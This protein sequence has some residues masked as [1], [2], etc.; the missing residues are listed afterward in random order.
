MSQDLKKDLIIKAAQKRFSHFGVSKT[1]MN[2]IADDLSISKA[3]LYYY[4]PDKLN[5]YAAVLQKIIETEESNG[6]DPLKEKDPQVA[7]VSYLENRTKF[8]IQH[9]NILEY[10]KTLGTAVP[11]ELEPIFSSA[12]TREIKSIASIIKKGMEQKQLK[13]TDPQKTAELFL[14]CL[15]GLRTSAVSNKS[16]FFPNKKQF[17]DLASREKEV[18]AIF[19]KGLSN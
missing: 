17:V 4:F 19:I 2:E 18:A 10:L 1:T 14:D 7:L 3:S 5:L 15:N 12:R 13:V 8:I 6:P 16:N 11:K 9:Y